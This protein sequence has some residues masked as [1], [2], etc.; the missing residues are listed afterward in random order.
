MEIALVHD[1]QLILGPIGFNV[2]M[3]NSELGDLEVS[4]RIDS[5]SFNQLPIHFSDNR[6]HLLIIE[7]EIPENDPKYHNIGNF[8]WEIIKDNDVPVRVK[9]TYSIADKSLDEVKYIFKQKVAPI[10]KEKENKIINIDISGTII[11]VST[12]REE[13]TLLV[14]KLLSS[15]GSHNFKFKNTWLQISEDDLRFIIS[16]I[17]RSVQDA[18]N[19]EFLKLQ[20]IDSCETIDDVHNVNFMD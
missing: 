9:L 8:E 6:T 19:W 3:I 16:E 18:F 7:K 17:D 15:P 4:E 20:E 5:K 11:Q 14:S 12:S 13:R 2:R 1:N 10:R